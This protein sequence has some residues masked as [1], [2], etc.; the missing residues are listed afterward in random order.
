MSAD[1]HARRLD[2]IDILK[3]TV[4]D[5]EK[6][7]IWVERA[8]A[9]LERAAENPPIS[10]RDL[11]YPTVPKFSTGSNGGKQWCECGRD[12]CRAPDCPSH[13]ADPLGR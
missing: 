7:L 13:K 2:D 11:D 12:V 10:W 4:A 9:R 1:E 3:R 5:I 6:R 8:I